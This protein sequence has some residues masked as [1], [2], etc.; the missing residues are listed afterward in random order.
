MKFTIWSLFCCMLLGAADREAYVQGQPLDTGQ[1][2]VLLADDAYVED[3]IGMTHVLGK[4]NKLP[5]NPVIV[6]DQPWE[7]VLGHPDVHFDEQAG[8]Y[9]MWYQVWNGPAWHARHSKWTAA[10]LT[11][12]QRRHWHAYFIGYATS[13]DGVRWDKPLLE[14]HRYLDFT[15][16]NIVHIGEEEAEAQRIYRNPDSSDP[17]RRLFMTYSDRLPDPRQGQSLMLAWSGDGVDWQVDREVSPLVTRV[18]DGSFDLARDEER[19]RWLLFRRPDYAS[20]ALKRQ[21]PYAAVRPN[22][23]YAV[24]VN[25]RLGPGWSHPRLVLTPHEEV[26]WRDIDT[27][28]VIREGTHY[29]ALLGMM[30]DRE[31]GLQQVHLAVS[32]DGLR[33]TRFPF[34]PAFIPRGPD[35]AFDAGQVQPPAVTPRGEFNYLY[36][37]GVNVGQRVQQGYYA[38]IGAARMRRGRWV[39]LQAGADGGYVLTRELRVTG[40][41]LE[42][43]FQGVIA[44][45]MQPIDGRPIGSIRVE[46]LRRSAVEGHLEPIPGFT[47][48]ESD[49]LVGD[50]LAAAVSWKGS[51][52]LTSL[53]GQPVYIRF[54][55]VQSELWGFRFR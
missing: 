16:T 24:S 7:D 3:K 10:T 49:P 36:Y 22:G 52:A 12:E 31:K 30:N 41:R 54:H 26:E 13:A 11:P 46:L 8:R 17:S 51:A 29:V 37:T 6:P 9:Q 28:R 27:M 1:K 14:R 19:Q 23:R 32:P 42:V 43:N 2:W 20:A 34:L 35:G 18:P 45:Y 4:V 48:P 5:N 38:A 39:G 40:G 53:R 33:W 50:G 15:R 47:F 21:G 44:P 25:N 55:V